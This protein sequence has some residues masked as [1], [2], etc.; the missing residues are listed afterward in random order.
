MVEEKVTKP[1][2]YEW[3]TKLLF[4]NKLMLKKFIEKSKDGKVWYEVK[5]VS[6]GRSLHL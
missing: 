5:T 1:R 3:I 4:R 6:P 2:G